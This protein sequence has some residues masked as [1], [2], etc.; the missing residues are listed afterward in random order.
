[1]Y[2][3]RAGGRQST[4]STHQG[5]KARRSWNFFEF[6]CREWNSPP[7]C[8]VRPVM[9][10]YVDTIH[11][12]ALWASRD[13][14]LRVGRAID[15][16]LTTGILVVGVCPAVQYLGGAIPQTQGPTAIQVKGKSRKPGCESG[17]QVA[18]RKS[19]DSAVIKMRKVT[20][21]HVHSS[22]R[23]AAGMPPYAN[24]FG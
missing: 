22:Q 7:I 5:L 15:A 9:N 24:R 4:D 10:S 12:W 18:K 2:Q 23:V 21:I 8:K 6:C 13:W 19:R 1:M 20:D 17:R 11:S 3:R 14:S 16:T